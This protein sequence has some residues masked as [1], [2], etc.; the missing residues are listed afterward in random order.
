MRQ[1][2]QRCMILANASMSSCIWPMRL[3]AFRMACSS[4]YCSTY[5]LMRPL[6]KGVIRYLSKPRLRC[7]EQRSRRA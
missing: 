5:R 1:M 3:K 4:T 7:L 6:K 2:L